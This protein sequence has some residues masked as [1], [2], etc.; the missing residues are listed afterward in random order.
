MRLR[1]TL[2]L[3][4]E[5]LILQFPIKCFFFLLLV[6]I[7]ISGRV[8]YKTHV[9]ELALVGQVTVACSLNLLFFAM[10]IERSLQVVIVAKAAG[11]VGFVSV[12]L[13]PMLVSIV[14]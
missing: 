14:I 13:F 3:V 9:L 8:S 2:K 10:L 4:G 1:T 12:S 6:K 7:E 5:I 11:S